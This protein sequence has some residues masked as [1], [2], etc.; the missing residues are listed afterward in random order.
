MN[1]TASSNALRAAQKVSIY[2]ST[3]I[4]ALYLQSLTD[5]PTCNDQNEFQ[6]VYVANAKQF[7]TCSQDQ[8]TIVNIDPSAASEPEQVIATISEPAGANCTNSS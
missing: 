8:W 1:V 4:R 7:L 6:L 5:I 3:Q 2:K